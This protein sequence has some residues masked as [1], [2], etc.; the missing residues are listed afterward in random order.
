MAQLVG[1]QNTRTT[2]R[3]RITDALDHD[4]FD[5]RSLVY[6][7]VDGYDGLD[8]NYHPEQPSKLRK[9]AQKQLREWF[10]SQ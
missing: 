8:L 6:R 7:E 9:R 10:D 3:I 4:S 1:P 2:V 5:V